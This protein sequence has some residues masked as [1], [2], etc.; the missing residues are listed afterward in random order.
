MSSLAAV[1]LC[2]TR[3]SSLRAPA[4]SICCYVSLSVSL[5]C[6]S[7]CLLLLLSR[8]CP[9]LASSSLGTPVSSILAAVSPAASCCC[10]CCWDQQ[11]QQQQQQ[12]GECQHSCPL[13][14]RSRGV[15]THRWIRNAFQARKQQ[16]QQ[17]QQQQQHQ[18]QRQQQQR[19]QLVSCRSFIYLRPGHIR[20]SERL[21]LR[22]ERHCSSSRCSSSSSSRSSRNLSLL[23]LLCVQD[24]LASRS[25]PLPLHVEGAPGLSCCCCCCCRPVCCCSSCGRQQQQHERRVLRLLLRF[26]LL[27]QLM[28]LLLLLLLPQGCRL[29]DGETLLSAGIVCL[30]QLS[31]L[32]LLQCLCC[33][34]VLQQQQRLLLLG[35]TCCCFRQRSLSPLFC[36]VSFLFVAVFAAGVAA[37]VWLSLHYLLYCLGFHAASLGLRTYGGIEGNLYSL[38]TCRH[39]SYTSFGSD[40]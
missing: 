33:L 11:T 38:Q 40:L 14:G 12:H 29:P 8:D 32:L 5:C 3:C 34:L 13:P 9:S 7:V 2:L 36:A 21:S 17:Q 28:V 4:V 30:H 20:S 18:L 22:L 6:C 23:L 10:C 26:S 31:P 15:R 16:Q 39:L 25:P 27:Q 24:P 1:S 35:C 19:R 37:A